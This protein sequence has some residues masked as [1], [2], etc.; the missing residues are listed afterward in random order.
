M[1]PAREGINDDETTIELPAAPD[2]TAK[3]D[4]NVLFMNEYKPRTYS[5]KDAI[6]LH[7]QCMHETGA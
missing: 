4:L 7:R 6:Q 5:I 3:R 1:F 2:L